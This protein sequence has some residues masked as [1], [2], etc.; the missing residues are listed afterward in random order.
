MATFVAGQPYTGK[1]IDPSQGGA[2]VDYKPSTGDR[3]QALQ[4]QQSGVQLTSPAITASELSPKKVNNFITTPPEVPIPDLTHL[5]PEPLPNP[6]ETPSN[7]GTTE[8]QYKE[9]LN[10]LMG[11]NTAIE[12]KAGYTAQQNE[13]LGV[14]AASDAITGLNSQLTG[15]INESKAIPLQIQQSAQEGGAN[16]TKGGLA[17]IQTAQLRNNA[18]QSLSVSSQI[19]AMNGQL[20]NAIKKVDRA[21]ALKY[22]DLEARQTTLTKN[23]EIFAKDPSLTLEEQDR[24]A[25]KLAE[26]KAYDAQIAD[27]KKIETDT[28][29]ARLKVLSN[30]SGKLT[31]QMVELLQAAQTPEEVAQLVNYLGLSTLSQKDQLDQ[32]NTER[33]FAQTQANANRAFNEQVRQFNVQQ[34][35]KAIADA[36]KALAIVKITEAKTAAAQ[37]QKEASLPVLDNKI[38]II[39]GLLANKNGLSAMVGPN[40]YSRLANPYTALI[41]SE[42]QDFIAG[43]N[44]LISQSTLDALLALKAQGGTLG[45]LSEKEGAM[46]KEAASKIGTWAIIKDG[47]TVGYDTSEKSFVDELNTIKASTQRIKD[48]I[49]ASKGTQATLSPEDTAQID[50]LYGDVNPASYF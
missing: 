48:A 37:Q 27:Q 45:A 23:L 32:Q 28:H 50:Q 7:L 36:R 2:V 44:Q 29:D 18:I 34:N 1:V 3:S 11:V 43:V 26:T 30:N 24:V 19:D 17:P 47:Q 39:D 31:Q 20:S 35:T 13:A 5:T 42:K 33:T 22:G 41:S 10:E 38:T 12:G 40:A 49:N 6:A 15:L 14:N 9:M 16:V 21:V 8:T 46:L 25:K 4:Q